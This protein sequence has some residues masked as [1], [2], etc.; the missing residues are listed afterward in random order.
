[1]I[2]DVIGI[3]LSPGHILFL[4]I[5]AFSGVVVGAIP[6]LSGAML[7]A[8]TLPLTFSMA[9]TDAVTLLVAQYVGAIGGGLLSGITLKIPGT[10]AAMLTALEGYP[11]A[12]RIGTHR[13]ITLAVSGCFFGGIVSACVLIVAAQPLTALSLR[14][15]KFEFFS[16]VFMSLIVVSSITEGNR[17]RGLLSAGLGVLASLPG[18]D[19]SSGMAR[20]TFGFQDMQSGFGLLPVLLGLFGVAQAMQSI[21]EPSLDVEGETRPDRGLAFLPLAKWKE[22]FVNL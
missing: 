18:I 4:I 2:S 16:L 11:L 5:G 9:T 17:L 10:P 15:G 20:L 8:L 22:H 21:I 13:A 14:F 7:I 12:Q 1:M 6:G 19:P 3:V